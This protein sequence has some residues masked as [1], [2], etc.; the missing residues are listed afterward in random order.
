MIAAFEARG[1]PLL[2]SYYRRSL[3]R[4]LELKAWL[5]QGLIGPV[6]QMRWHLS[7]TPSPRDLSGAPNWRT[8]LRTSPG[9]YFS[10]LASHGLDL[11]QFLVGDI[12]SASGVAGNRRGLYAAEDVV[13]ACWTFANGAVGSGSWNFGSDRRGDEVQIDGTNGRIVFS[14]FDEAR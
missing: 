10:D 2:V 7:R 6:H 5:A 3:P 12:T 9:G 8:D 14:V 1:L 13:A 4:F 11:F